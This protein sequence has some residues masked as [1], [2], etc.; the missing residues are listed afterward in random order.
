M[1]LGS[2]CSE[3]DYADCLR[4]SSSTLFS[5]CRS[6][7]S[8]CKSGK[9][10]Y[11]S[12]SGCTT[13]HQY[14]SKQH[15]KYKRRSQQD[16]DGSY[17]RD[18]DPQLRYN[19]LNR[20]RPEYPFSIE[21]YLDPQL[22]SNS[23]NRD[24]PEYPFNDKQTSDY[25]SDYQSLHSSDNELGSVKS[26]Y[27]DTSTRQFECSSRSSV[28]SAREL[29]ESSTLTSCETV[30]HGFTTHCEAVQHSFA[31]TD[32]TIDVTDDRYSTSS[33]KEIETDVHAY[34][35]LV[36]SN[37]HRELYS[38]E[39][40]VVAHTG[41]VTCNI[42][43]MK[44]VNTDEDPSN[45]E[46]N[47][48]MERPAN[49]PVSVQSNHNIWSLSSL[50]ISVPDGFQNVES[51]ALLPDDRYVTSVPTCTDSVTTGCLDNKD[52]FVYS[53]YPIHVFNHVTPQPYG[54]IKKYLCFHSPDRPSLKRPTL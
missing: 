28:L 39:N 38:L 3:S 22:K 25:C 21:K 37:Q 42:I 17:F 50:C 10:D 36:S 40:L 27:T 9:D 20:D 51:N 46:C 14:R 13:R 16:H 35:L 53:T 44:D 26:S 48:K 7:D 43:P 49:V 19:S 32:E 52:K 47:D 4:S 5:S 45:K 29:H 41:E 2:V 15:R 54:Q 6:Y 11:S 18:L 30:P 12:D 8:G 1:E 31:Y 33:I 23:L 34:F 24:C